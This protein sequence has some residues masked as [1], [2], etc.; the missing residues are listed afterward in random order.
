MSG[1]RPVFAFAWNAFALPFAILWN[2]DDNWQE[3]QVVLLLGPFGIGVAWDW[4]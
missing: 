3:T 4:A 1:L 2:D